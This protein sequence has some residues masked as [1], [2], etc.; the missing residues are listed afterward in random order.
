[1]SGRTAGAR[2]VDAAMAVKTKAAAAGKATVRVEPDPEPAPAA[3]VESAA[4][5][6]PT[7]LDYMLSVMRDPAVEPGRRDEMAKLALP[8]MHP[9]AAAEQGIDAAPAQPVA[10]SET[11]IA[12]RIAFTFA[13]A[14]RAP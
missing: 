11:E 4:P 7:P 10:L 5:A 3:I 9:K 1:M 12:R 14:M 13:K 8:Y 6:S 2:A